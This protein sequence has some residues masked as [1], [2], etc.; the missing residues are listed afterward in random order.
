MGSATADL[1]I[2]ALRLAEAREGARTAE[3]DRLVRVLL[4]HYACDFILGDLPGLCWLDPTERFPLLR[5]GPPPRD[6]RG[7]VVVS[8]VMLRML[9]KEFP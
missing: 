5:E 1:E 9:A 3:F 7:Y 8:L 4:P 2:A 6:R